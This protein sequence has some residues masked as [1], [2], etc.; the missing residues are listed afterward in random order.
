M[1]QPLCLIPIEDLVIDPVP[2]SSEE[3]EGEY[4]KALVESGEITEVDP[5][6]LDKVEE[7][8]ASPN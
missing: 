3:E 7:R 5:S 8:L 2:V 6:E 1:D 4:S